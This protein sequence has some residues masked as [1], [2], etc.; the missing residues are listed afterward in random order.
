MQTIF[1]EKRKRLL[2]DLKVLA[3]KHNRD[4]YVSLIPFVESATVDQEDVIDM[5]REALDED[6]VTLL[7]SRNALVTVWK[8]NF[9]I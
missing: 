9:L 8:F 3:L 7:Q 1:E 2:D 4:Y 5:Y 6:R